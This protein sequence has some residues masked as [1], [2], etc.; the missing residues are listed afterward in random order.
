MRKILSKLRERARDYSEEDIL[1]MVDESVKATR[2]EEET[3]P[4]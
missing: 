3:R 1:R 4:H 2:L